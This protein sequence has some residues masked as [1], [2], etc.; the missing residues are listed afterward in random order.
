MTIRAWFV[1]CAGVAVVFGAGEAAHAQVE[2]LTPVTDQTLQNPD[3]ADWLSWRRTLDGWGYSPLDQIDRA[4]VGGLRLAWSWGMEPGVSQTTPSCTTASCTSRTR[5][6]SCRP[7]TPAAATSSGRVPAR[8]GRGAPPARRADAEPRDLRGPDH[9]EH[10]RRP[11]R[12]ARRP[13]RRGALGDAGHAHRGGATASRAV[14]SSP[15]A[16]SWPGCGGASGSARTPATSSGSTPAPARCCGARRPSPA[17]ASAAATPGATCR[18]CSAPAATRGFPAATTP[19][20]GSSSTA[21]PRPSP[22]RATPAAP[23]ATRS[24]ATRRSPSTPPPAR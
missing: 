13:H 18:C 4:N 1:A 3:P 9:P 15:A 17:P 7:C 2:T 6:T 19:R 8:D 12:R 11:R 20:R 22:G 24:T 10:R 5:G 14:R 23:T 16:S 21:R